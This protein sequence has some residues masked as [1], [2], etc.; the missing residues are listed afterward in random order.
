MQVSI[1]GVYPGR[2]GIA[3]QVGLHLPSHPALSCAWL[4]ID[5]PEMSGK[6]SSKL[7]PGYGPGMCH[8]YRHPSVPFSLARTSLPTLLGVYMSERQS[9]CLACVVQQGFQGILNLLS[10]RCGWLEHG[11]HDATALLSYS[12]TTGHH[13]G[14][15]VSLFSFFFF[16]N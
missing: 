9:C 11:H 6:K 3:S 16:F 13:S 15:R 7:L 8:I 14:D 5:H 10:R 1:V 2:E 12:L 4:S